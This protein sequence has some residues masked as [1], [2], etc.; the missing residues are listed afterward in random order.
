MYPYDT[1][2]LGIA[3]SLSASIL[4]LSCIY[5]ASIGLSIFVRAQRGLDLSG[6]NNH[7]NLI[8]SNSKISR[9][10]PSLFLQP[11]TMVA[12]VTGSNLQITKSRPPQIP[13]RH[14]FQSLPLQVCTF[15]ERKVHRADSGTGRRRGMAGSGA[16]LVLLV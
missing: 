13:I 15:E 14:G 16:S 8:D 2:P 6:S 9:A 11:R 3:G 7:N 1:N 10:Y 12:G 5:P 4:H